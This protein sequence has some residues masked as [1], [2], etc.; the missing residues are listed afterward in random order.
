MHSLP[1]QF[2]FFTV[3]NRSNEKQFIT[4]CKS[5]HF[6][7]IQ[8]CICKYPAKIWIVDVFLAQ[9]SEC[10]DSLVII[11]LD[12][13]FCTS[14]QRNVQLLGPGFQKTRMSNL[15][16]KCP[17]GQQGFCGFGISITSKVYSTPPPPKKKMPSAA[18]FDI[19]PSFK[20]SASAT[21]NEVN[22]VMKDWWRMTS[23]QEHLKASCSCFACLTTAL[24]HQLR[25][26][27]LLSTKTLN[28]Y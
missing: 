25:I 10:Q 3:N 19:K 11:Q 7:G 22:R 12:S 28:H 15:A 27:C 20:V 18:F 26:V 4:F 5:L 24:F 14:G 8:L 16:L 2:K 1:F 13:S 9:S 17:Y 21:P 23:L 6:V